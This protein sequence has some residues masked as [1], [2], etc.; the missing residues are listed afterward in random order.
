MFGLIR[1]CGCRLS[2]AQK[3]AW[4]SHV[5]GLCLALKD[6][7]G[8]MAR[9]ATNY[10]AALLSVLYEAQAGRP[11]PT[12]SHVCALR[13]FHRA[14]VVVGADT[15]AQYAADVALLMAATRLNDAVAD[16]D[17]WLG[18]PARLVTGLARRWSRAA[19][20]AAARLRAPTQTI[21]D[22]ARR[23]PQVEQQA[24]QHFLFYSEPTERAVGAAFE[25]TA[26][27]AGCPA[28][29]EP[30]FQVGRMFGRIM[31]LLDS[32]RD[33]AADISAGKF[34]PLAACFGGQERDSQAR[35]LFD[36]A[37]GELKRQFERLSLPQPALARQLLLL[38]LG[39]V[40]YRTLAAGAA[41]APA[42]TSAMF[43]N[44]RP[45]LNT[46]G[47]WDCG[48]FCGTTC[49]VCAC[50]GQSVECCTG[51]VKCSDG[52]CGCDGCDGCGCGD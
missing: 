38:Q 20:R 9:L 17:G 15:G 41:C 37:Y 32:Y 28:N 11:A 10:D 4:Q 34:N 24:G 5:C 27:M 46:T 52:G 19:H 16:Q 39:H 36:E 47:G 45:P 7:Y 3:Q 40:G 2:R 21:E 18:R 30:L 51:C 13:G 8:Q 1:G 26:R 44:R 29:A 33:Y 23:Q 35:R 22:Q 48:Q 49:E 31:V 6:R 12:A 42:G 50:C 43:S 14:E 25:H